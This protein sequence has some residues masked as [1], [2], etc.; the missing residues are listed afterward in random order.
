[1]LCSRSGRVGSLGLW[2]VALLHG[3]G[4]GDAEYAEIDSSLS[5]VEAGPRADGGA[6]QDA[7]VD[8]A[9]SVRVDA[10]EDAAVDAGA[11]FS[12]P[13]F[14]VIVLEGLRPDMVS[15]ELMPNLVGLS[16]RGVTFDQ[17]LGVF[18]SNSL[19]AAASL[20][21]GA[22]PT[23]HGVYGERVYLPGL[24]IR[25]AAGRTYTT[26]QPFS[27]NDY[28]SM[29]SLH[30]QLKG[31]LLSARSV[32]EV[33]RSAGAK[34]AF[35]GRSGPVSLQNYELEGMHVDEH[36]VAP[37]AL[38]KWAATLSFAAEGASAAALPPYTGY[39]FAEFANATSPFAVAT[40]TRSTLAP[41]PVYDKPLLPFETVSAP[42]DDLIGVG[43]GQGSVDPS[44]VLL[45]SLYAAGNAYFDRVEKK[46]V[47]SDELGGDLTLYWI[48][49][50][51]ATL[52]RYGPN[53]D[54]ARA[55]LRQADRL[56]GKAFNSRVFGEG[57]N[58]NVIV[59]SDHGFSTVAG[60]RED[61]PRYLLREPGFQAR[62]TTTEPVD[63]LTGQRLPP[64]TT[65]TWSP[66]AN[67]LVPSPTGTAVPIDGEVRLAWLLR[68]AGFG[69]AV[70]GAGEPIAGCLDSHLSSELLA[71]SGV[72]ISGKVCLEPADADPATMHK[73]T[74]VLASNE[75][76]EQL[77]LPKMTRTGIARLVALLQGRPELGAIF[78]SP[79]LGKI[80]GTLPLKEV[81]LEHTAARHPDI[82]VAYAWDG[83]DVANV[84]HTLQARSVVGQ[85]LLNYTAAECSPSSPNPSQQCREGLWCNTVPMSGLRCVFCPEIPDDPNLTDDENASLERAQ[86]TCQSTDGNSVW[87]ASAAVRRA[88]TKYSEVGEPCET[89][90]VCKPGLA[91]L[92]FDP[93]RPPTFVN[94]GVCGTPGSSPLVASP[95]PEQVLKG[96]SYAAVRDA[97]GVSGGGAPAELA[98]VLIAAG[99]AF[100]S[101][102]HAKAASG[103]VDIAPTIAHVM[104]L[105][106]SA[107][108][109]RVL[110]E[111]LVDGASVEEGKASSLA[112]PP[113]TTVRV[114][115]ATRASST[116][117]DVAYIGSF[118]TKV[119]IVETKAGGK[120]YRYITSV[121]A[122]RKK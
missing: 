75:G 55:A 45:D 94:P 88:Q 103:L 97:R 27:L 46:L 20:A 114:F 2:L 7:G 80:P 31:G 87:N 49:E 25:D 106:F 85:T 47:A 26:S 56:L 63:P 41:I 58:L 37:Y 115:R 98:T 107:P 116:D 19:T 57:V 33:A 32:F 40:A 35:V 29:A 4:D 48:R 51:A 66:G 74:I 89:S 113:A 39:L 61:F 71:S 99:P 96:T 42:A 16:K 90:A 50:P 101:G 52:R 95:L 64:T 1:M 15:E 120:V 62:V 72:A 70:D 22:Y 11:A 44:R 69:H 118:A 38:A 91:C 12:G 34:T 81:Q 10:G 105:D 121:G 36:V 108:H 122:V 76:T 43:P 102:V 60:A 111:A 28:A 92:S 24:T 86:E 117:A 18:P 68:N 79:R 65:T 53:S 73:D 100:K 109:G 112:A 17:Q 3:C 84:P 30:G 5:A 59:A 78:V 119:N 8:D 82:I 54:T 110:S 9:G 23:G 67:G 83:E 21:T 6:V 13:R 104:G 93:A 14:L 77:Y